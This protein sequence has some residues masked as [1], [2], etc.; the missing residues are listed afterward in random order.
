MK[1]SQPVVFVSFE[2]APFAKVGGLADVAGA[3]P[4]A[5]A[6][7]G[8]D[9]MVFAPRFGQLDVVALGCEEEALPD[10]WYVGI[11]WKH[12]PMRVWRGE[13]G[14]EVPLRLVGGDAFFGRHGIYD[15]EDA[16]PFPDEIERYVFFCKA[17]V[18]YLKCRGIAPSVVHAN[19]H[20]TA[21]ALA[22]VRELYAHETIFEQ[23][24]TVYSI[25]NLA[26]QGL[27]APDRLTT[28][29]LDARRF[30]PMGPY[31]F[32]GS[33]NLMKLGVH[34]ADAVNTV[35]PT[36]A[37]EIMT[38]DQGAGLDG[39]LQSVGGKV[40]GILNG[41]DDTVWNPSLDA[42]IPL[43]YDADNLGAKR[44]CKRELLREAGLPDDRVGRPLVGMVGRLVAQKGIDLVAPILDRLLDADVTVVALGSGATEL[45]DV[46]REAATRRPDRMGARIG[47]DDALA[48][49]ITAGA[50]I[51]LMPSRYEPCGLNQMYAMAYGTIPVVRR[52]GGLA[53][54]VQP[55]DTSTGEGTGF[56]F[57][58]PTSDALAEALWRAVELW[59]DPSRW[60][61]LMRNAMANDFSWRGRAAEYVAMYEWAG[62]NRG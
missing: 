61:R 27:Y 3:L 56:L 48:H 37:R 25:H 34:Y 9:V 1:N 58:D 62:R 52:T 20:Q 39:Y 30:E 28:M 2:V 36:Y 49:R 8:V 29:S 7:E 50:D 60:N 26:Y 21:L 23:T 47:F 24:A 22:Y 11:D 17:V 55:Y 42:K 13:L 16:Q 59:N 43:T 32:H 4:V 54:T 33:V 40:R 53:D 10:D 35:S 14:G 6:K 5:L 45:E 41:I 46:F 57:D 18:E 31:E 15:D 38:P 12:Y 44:T 19:D 51:F